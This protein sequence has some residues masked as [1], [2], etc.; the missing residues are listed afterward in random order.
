MNREVSQVV[1]LWLVQME[2]EVGDKQG[3]AKKI[4]EYVNRAVE[5]AVDLVAFPELSLT[6]Y[7]C[8]ETFFEL[9]EPIPGPST[10]EIEQEARRKGIYVTFGMPELEGTRIYNSAPLFGP[11]GLVGV[12]RKLILAT[13]WTPTL[14]YDEGMYFQPGNEIVTFKTRFGK[15]GVVICRDILYPEITR[16]HCYRG[17]LLLLCLSA[18]P[19]PER[20][21]V[22]GRART[23]E[24]FAWLGYVNQAGAQG[25]VKLTGG[26]CIISYT[27]SIEKVAS[28]GEQ[29]KEEI[30]EQEIDLDAT[31]RAKLASTIER[32]WRT[33]I[34]RKAT[35]VVSQQ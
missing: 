9:A 7:A 25:N 27:N 24:G 26:S 21:H 10:M 29:A 28:I 5:A 33:D 4:L 15:L 34:L 6:G 20:F 35:E 30:I 17:A 3:N 11:Y 2:C 19:F 8:H 16:V 32:V 23:Q 13:A 14:I 18:V 22:Y 12:W 1:K 31:S